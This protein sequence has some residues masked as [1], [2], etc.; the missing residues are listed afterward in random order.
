MKWLLWVG[1]IAGNVLY[2]PLH[3]IDLIDIP[4]VFEKEILALEERVEFIE[5]MGGKLEAR[6]RSKPDG[7]VHTM[8]DLVHMDLP[9]LRL[10]IARI[11]DVIEDILQ[12]ADAVP[13]GRGKTLQKLG[14]TAA[15]YKLVALVW[16]E[17]EAAK[18]PAAA[19]LALDRYTVWLKG[20]VTDRDALASAKAFLITTIGQLSNDGVPVTIDAKMKMTPRDPSISDL[21]KEAAATADT[22][23]SE[24]RKG[25]LVFLKDNFLGKGRVKVVIR[26][27]DQAANRRVEISP[28]LL[29]GRPKP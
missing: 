11:D 14:R 17:A 18:D 4:Y 8:E 23:W 2:Q 15:L 12:D 13:H 10:F 3:A 24:D 16:S 29:V 21:L 7:E 1:M 28:V 26:S 9:N 5:G 6:L 27:A 22:A 19:V 20:A 25:Y